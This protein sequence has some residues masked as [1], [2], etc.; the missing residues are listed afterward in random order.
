MFNF[1]NDQKSP[2]LKQKITKTCFC[3]SLFKISLKKEKI[4]K[5]NFELLFEL[6]TSPYFA[7]SHFLFCFCFAFCF[8]LFCFLITC[9]I[10]SKTGKFCKNL[11]QPLENFPCC[12]LTKKK[13]TQSPIGNLKY[14][15][16]GHLIKE[17]NRG[18]PLQGR[19]R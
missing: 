12:L 14:I 5:L 8:V 1:K 3:Y 7:F 2:F 6:K 9:Q 10:R 17:K 18:Y 16:C 11:N 19:V 4:L 15:L 13:V